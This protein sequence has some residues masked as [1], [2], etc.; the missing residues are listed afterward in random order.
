MTTAVHQLVPVFSYGDAIGAATLQTRQMLHRLG[1]RSETFAE[2]I[3]PRLGDAA[4][5]ATELVSTLRDGDAVLYRLSIGSPLAGLFE[6]CGAR[7][8]IVYH[9]ITPAKYFSGTNPRVT[10]WVERGRGDLRRLAPIA[11]LVV[12]DSTYNLDEA[13]AAGARHTAVVPPPVDLQRLSPH[14]SRP[15]WPPTVLFVG[16]VAPNK[17][18][19]T[20]LR[21]LVALRATAIPDARLALVGSADDTGTYLGRLRDLVAR[22]GLAG[23]VDLEDARVTDT[24][25][26]EHYAGAAVFATASE[27]EGFCVPLVEAMAFEVPI[28][29][30]AAGAIPET[31]AGA[32]LLLDN[33]DPLLWAAALERAIRDTVVRDAL[34][35]AG[36]DR[37]RTLAEPVIRDRL[38]TALRSAKILP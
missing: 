17:R 16:R 32:A 38:G 7:R 27:H 6:R 9:N 24:R 22:L 23:A 15:G 33:R 26:G 34:V 28:V 21:A 4:R 37:L 1:Y 12:A 25:L 18:H 19:D 35:A 5:P 8:V 11:D 13:L 2:V 14:P 30:F 31:A 3:D 10:Y 29:A 20:L 36:R